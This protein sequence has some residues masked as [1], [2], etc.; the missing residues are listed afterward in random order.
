MKFLHHS[1]EHSRDDVINQRYRIVVELGR[2]ACGITYE[3]EDLTSYQRVALKVLPIKQ[4]DNW[5]VMKLFAREARVLQT[6]GH[7]NIPKYLD[8]FYLDSNQDRCFYLV[9]EL[10]E[11]RSLADWVASG[12]YAT[13]QQIWQIAMRVLNILKYLH[14]LRK[15]I[16]HRDINPH[17][18]IRQSDGTIF[19]VDFGGI[20]EIYRSTISRGEGFTNVQGSTFV[21]TL[22]YMPPEQ[23]RGDVSTASDLYALGATLLFLATHRSP[24]DLPRNRLKIDLSSVQ[25]SPKLQSWLEQMLEPTPE[26]RLASVREAAYALGLATGSLQQKYRQPAG[27]KV[28]FKRSDRRLVVENMPDR[29]GIHPFLAILIPLAAISI[30]NFLASSILRLLGSIFGFTWGFTS[31]LPM[32]MG[33]AVLAISL[34]IAVWLNFHHTSLEIDERGFSICRSSLN[35]RRTFRGPRIPLSIYRDEETDE[36]KWQVMGGIILETNKEIYEVGVLLQVDLPKENGW[37]Q[38]LPIF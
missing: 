20:K 21:G 2:G 6:L 1:G 14:C 35:F 27:S 29:F 17:N 28:R 10:V 9:R 19:L 3:A 26:N 30:I 24:A 7:S 38:K 22:G 8:D 4:S 23:F 18:I 32:L 13:E 15:P 12:W 33:V 5:Q 16:I 36:K 34:P 37:K 11:G 31:I 25:L